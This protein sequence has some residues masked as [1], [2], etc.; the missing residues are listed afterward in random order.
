[1][2][3]PRCDRILAGTALALILAAPFGLSAQETG[4]ETGKLPAP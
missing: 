1:M 3:G 2:G 4:K